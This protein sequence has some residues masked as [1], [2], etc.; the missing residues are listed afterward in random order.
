M[1]ITMPCQGGAESSSQSALDA[2]AE[3]VIVLQTKDLE[4]TGTISFTGSR[5]SIE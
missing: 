2:I 1:D 5:L 4:L 3:P